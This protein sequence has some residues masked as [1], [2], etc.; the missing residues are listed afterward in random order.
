MSEPVQGRTKRLMSMSDE[1]A[2]LDAVLLLESL[3]DDTD[4]CFFIR[5][6]NVTLETQILHAIFDALKTTKKIKH[7]SLAGVGM[8]DEDGL[9]FNEA[10]EQN[11]TLETVN[12]E[13]NDLT[14]IVMEPLFALMEKHPTIREFKCA[15]QKHGLGSRGE[16]AMA[17]ALD[18]NERLLKISYP[19][20]VQS[21]RSLADR[22]QIRNND[23]LRKRRTSG[24]DFY[25]YKEE[26]K[27]RDEHPQPWIKEQEDKNE[28]MKSDLADQKGRMKSVPNVGKMRADAKLRAKENAKPTMDNELANKLQ[29]ARK[30]RGRSMKLT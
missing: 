5:I 19:F 25:N 26:I 9:L 11:D 23:K 6:N 1:D 16:E 29:A 7:L 27:K 15:H 8:K 24:C 22:C 12:L 20:K 21:A 13:S 28:K 30:S 4:D 10:F 3:G 17:R 14:N 2:D 18:K